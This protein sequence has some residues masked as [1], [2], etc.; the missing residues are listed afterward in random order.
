MGFDAEL[1][2]RGAEQRRNSR[3][4]NAETVAD[5]LAALATGG[6]RGD[7]ELA[8]GEAARPNEDWKAS[9]IS[10]TEMTR[11]KAQCA[12]SPRMAGVQSLGA[13]WPS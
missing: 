1:T 3:A 9:D 6:V 10:S 2:H 4:G 8:L 7:L 11:S 13:D 12:T 5:E